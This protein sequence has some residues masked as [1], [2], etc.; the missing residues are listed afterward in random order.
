MLRLFFIFVIWFAA[1]NP[2][3]ATDKKSITLDVSSAKLVS[4]HSSV[5]KGQNFQIGF[6]LRPIDGW[7]SYWINPGD[8]GAP[9]IL[10]WTVPDGVIVSEGR[11]EAPER[12]PSGGLMTYGYAR[13]TTIVYDV[14]LPENYNKS[15]VTFSVSGEWLVCDKEC[16]P[17]FGDLSLTLPVGESTLVLDS[18]ELSDF[19]ANQPEASW[20]D[21]NILDMGNTV[22]LSLAMTIEE[23]A[24]FTDAY[25][26]PHQEGVIVYTD[27]PAVTIFDDG[28]LLTFQRPGAEIVPKTVSGVL[29]LT[30]KNGEKLFFNIHPVLSD[31]TTERGPAELDTDFALTPQSGPQMSIPQALVF[32]FLGGLILNL[33][34]CVFPV[35]SLKAFAFMQAGSMEKR[36]RRMEG[37]SYT[38]GILF[39]FLVIGVLLLVLRQSSDI[40]WGFQLQD[41]RFVAV[42]VIILVIMTLSLAGIFH[43]STGLEGA[44]QSLTTKDGPV[45]A[46][47]TGMLA[48]LVATPCTAPL[49]A[50]AIGFAF[51]QSSLI[52]L[53]ILLTLGFGLAFPFL[54]LSYS[55]TLAAKMPRPG[56]WM[57]KVKQGLAFPMLMTALWLASVYANQTGDTLLLLL[58]ATVIAFLIWL[59]EQL[60]GRLLRTV[61]LLLTL[62][63]AAAFIATPGV[64]VKKSAVE[65]S[66]EAES[67]LY[68]PERVKA[69]QQEG[70]PVFV[71]FTADWCITCKVNERVA[72]K[73]DETQAMFG[74]HNITVLVSDETA[75]LSAH[76][77]AILTQYGRAGIPLY[78]YYPM[79]G[80]EARLLP[81]VITINIL[82]DYIV[83]KGI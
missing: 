15:S 41:P 46:F 43:I 44:G 32:A 51:S 80:S 70:K 59:R 16:I 81:S 7:H 3:L 35:L 18:F 83:G 12:L 6:H 56:P 53:I 33:M 27:R 21:S 5:A 67:T 37:W 34:P 71:Y 45:G 54:L 63:L 2:A 25:F 28:L 75:G 62:G 76:T 48:T 8:S 31:W 14:S 39:S 11:F 29:E 38:A 40:L 13:P 55:E 19:Y 36:E 10:D 65:T 52:M 20:W 26:F 24:D 66:A 9:P 77:Q 42:M 47:F 30:Q 1:F 74:Q 17:Q 82:K 79:D 57:E 73:R 22:D 23:S 69:L 60:T 64:I 49:M 50:P 4:S 61:I 68:T 58:V 72:L 78:L